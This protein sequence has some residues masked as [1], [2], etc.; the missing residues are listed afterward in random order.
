MTAF[1]NKN[2]VVN[3]KKAGM[4]GMLY[5]PIDRTGLMKQVNEHYFGIK[6]G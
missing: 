6:G 1:V 2:T 3:C 4:A 5:K